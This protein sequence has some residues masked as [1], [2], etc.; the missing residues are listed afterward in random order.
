MQF[1]VKHFLPRPTKHTQMITTT[2]S[3]NHMIDDFRNKQ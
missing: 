2:H 3:I 1:G